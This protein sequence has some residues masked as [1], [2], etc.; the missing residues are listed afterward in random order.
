MSSLSI[1]SLL[2]MKTPAIGL[3]PR[4]SPDGRWLSVTLSSSRPHSGSK[5]VSSVNA[6]CSQW[7]YDLRQKTGFEIIPDPHCS[8]WSGVWSPS[9]NKLAF[10]CDLGGEAGIWIWSEET[11]ARRVGD[12]VA[13]PFYGYEYPV[14]TLDG[15]ALILKAMPSEEVDES[16]F[17]PPSIEPCGTDPI[18]VYRSEKG[19]TADPDASPLTFV[20]RYRADIVKVNIMSGEIQVLA[21]GLHPIEM[22]IS[23]DGTMLAFASRAEQELMGSQQLT[24]DLWVTPIHSPLTGS[25]R[26]IARGLK[27]EHPT[28]GWADDRTII[29]TTSGPLADGGLWAVSILAGT[30]APR[31]LASSAKI[32]FHPHSPPIPLRNG[33]VLLLGRRRLWHYHHQTGDIKQVA[34]EWDHHVMNI[35]SA[36]VTKDDTCVIVQTLEPGEMLSGFY[37]VDLLSGQR[38]CILEQP[39]KIYSWMVGGATMGRVDDKEKLIYFAESENEPVFAGMLDMGTK[40]IELAWELNPGI[41]SDRLSTVKLLQW[42]LGDVQVKGVLMLPN[43]VK[44]P[45]PVIVRIYAGERMS[46]RLRYFGCSPFSLENHHLLTSQGYAVFL[47]EV[48]VTGDE[49]ADAIARG[50]DAAIQALVSRADI[51]SERIG[52]IGHSFG[53]Y[54]TMVALTRLRWFKAAVVSA[55]FANLISKATHFDPRA[56]DYFFGYVEDGQPGLQETLWQNPQ[57]YVRNSP[58]FEFDRIQAP[59]LILQGTEDKVCAAQAGPMYAAL[60]RLGKTAEYVRYHGEGHAPIGWKETNKKDY[61][62]RILDWLNTHL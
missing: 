4:L 9:G 3:P 52:I 26:C 48:P 7:L 13:R 61:L 51:D 62:R 47:P 44:G 30:S 57:K 39:R 43:R 46:E 20:N 8:S 12:C 41:P 32:Q 17:G 29:Y 35:V 14:W 15:D 55:G 11:G 1:E 49:P 22:A 18:S 2:Q 27:M 10:Y 16:V 59:V 56:Q 36:P 50:L 37:R 25:P 38:E 58:I 6:G 34:S 53:G 33:N 23:P 28:F 19:Q 42:Q 21:E 5:G 54:N 31:R 40:Q 24:Y 60:R 45:V